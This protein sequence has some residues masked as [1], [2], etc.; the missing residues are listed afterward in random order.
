M[1]FFNIMSHLFYST[2]NHNHISL[3]KIIFSKFLLNFQMYR[4]E[5][6]PD[7]VNPV[8]PVPVTVRIIPDMETRRKNENPVTRR[9]TIHVS[10]TY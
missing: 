4:L 5:M 8:I 2:R 3:S 10:K 9:L 1:F 6:C 7:P